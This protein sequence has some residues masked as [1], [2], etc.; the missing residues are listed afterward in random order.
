MAKKKKSIDQWMRSL[1]RDLGYFTIGLTLI[2]ALSGIVLSVRGLGWFK[3]E[4]HTQIVMS[5]NISKETFN[6]KFIEEIKKGNLSLVFQKKMYPKIEKRLRLKL[7]E[8][9][10]NTS[11]FTAWRALKVTYNSDNGITD[12]VYKDYPK[13]VKIF[14]DAHKASHESAWFYLAM[15]YSVVLS[16][17]A[18]SAMFMVKGKYGFKKRGVYLMLAGIVVV[19]AFLLIS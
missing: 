17:F 6:K 14:L 7:E 19:I 12:V 16:F 8:E 4:I 1:H 13:A 2:Y 15:F 3:Q 9:T 11:I 5:S 10:L 18:I